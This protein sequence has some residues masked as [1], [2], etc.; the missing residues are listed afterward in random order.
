MAFAILDEG[1]H[2]AVAIAGFACVFLEGDAA[3]REARAHIRAQG[4][5]VLPALIGFGHLLVAGE[6]IEE[7]RRHQ[8]MDARHPFALE[9]LLQIA[10]EI[11]ALLLDVGARSIQLEIDHLRRDLEQVEQVVELRAV[12]IEDDALERA[13]AQVLQSDRVLVAHRLQVLGHDRCH[14]LHFGFRTEGADALHFFRQHHVVVRDVRNGKGAQ[15]SLAA[16]TYRPGRAH[17]HRRQQGQDAVFF[18]DGHRTEAHRLGRKQAHAFHQPVVVGQ[19][20]DGSGQRRHRKRG[21]LENVVHG[22]T[23]LRTRMPR[24]L[25][26]RVA[27]CF[28]AAV[29]AAGH[30]RA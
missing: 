22:Q 6:G 30:A 2:V 3:E 7:V 17:R 24:L 13:D 12:G 21:I 27:A 29:M 9:V 18:L 15:L 11:E 1:A 25:S 19:D 28:S 16:H 20:V 10:L 23:P 8:A 5:T 14:G 26:C 4:K